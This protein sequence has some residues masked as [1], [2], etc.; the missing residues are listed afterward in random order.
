M[1]I[2]KNI[3]LYGNSNELIHND[4]FKGNKG[5]EYKLVKD[6]T[7]NIINHCIIHMYPYSDTYDESGELNGYA[8]SL[9]FKAVVYNLDTMECCIL[10]KKDAI[11]ID[12]IKTKIRIFKD[13]STLIEFYEPIYVNKFGQCFEILNRHEFEILNRHEYDKWFS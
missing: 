3:K 4:F 10:T 12:G 8:D 11:E 13:M 9:F 2:N 5:F 6:C 7:N 1:E